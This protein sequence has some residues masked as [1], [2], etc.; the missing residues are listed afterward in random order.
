MPEKI[1]EFHI[2]VRFDGVQSLNDYKYVVEDY[3]ALHKLEKKQRRFIAVIGIR[4]NEDFEYDIGDD[5]M[6]K[7]W[8]VNGKIN[9]QWHRRFVSLREE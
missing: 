3:V 2:G 7:Q 6:N 9:I 4:Y 8:R 1:G 5:N